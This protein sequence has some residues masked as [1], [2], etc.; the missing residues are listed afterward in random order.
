MSNIPT[1]FVSIHAVVSVM[2]EDGS[3][4]IL[5]AEYTGNI[6]EIDASLRALYIASSFN[7]SH[8]TMRVVDC[9]VD[10]V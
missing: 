2:S 8:I 6:W 1:T 4:E 10:F 3:R 9:G 7:M 5:H